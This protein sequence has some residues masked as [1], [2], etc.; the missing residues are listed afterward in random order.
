MA[1]I[2][3]IGE[4]LW[5]VFPDREIL[6]GAALNFAAHAKNLGHPVSFISAVGNDERGNRVL[7]SMQNLGLATR[8]VHRVE[9]YPTGTVT[10]TL[11]TN[12][13][14]D[15]VIHRPVAYDFPALSDADLVELASLQPKW[16]YFGLLFQMSLTAKTLTLKLLKS[17]PN[18]RRFFDVN[19]R[20]NCYN[21]A[22]ISELLPL[23]NVVKLNDQEADELQS[24]LGWSYKSLE[25]FCRETKRQFG[26]EAVCVTRGEAGCAML[27]RTDYVE[28][29]GYKVQVADTVGAGDAF[30]AALA[31]GLDLGWP[32]MEIADFA[33]RVGALVSSRPGGTPTWT[34]Q[35]VQA[36]ARF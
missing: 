10:V 9:G 25:A 17:F 19:L 31:H 22:L 7:Q 11:D 12:G 21:P 26:W 20:K 13:I 36:L 6:G 35:E 8:F 24:M 23:A 32:A 30:S 14:P 16:I 5:D 33:N 34:L 15:F 1:C 4:V 28:D 2:F 29:R 27:V 3:S 18:A